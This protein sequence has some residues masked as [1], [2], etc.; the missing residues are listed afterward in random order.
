[1]CNVFARCMQDAEFCRRLANGTLLA[2]S[3]RAHAEKEGVNSNRNRP[4]A[5]KLRGSILLARS[6]RN[7]NLELVAR[8][9]LANGRRTQASGTEFCRRLANGTL[10]A[11]SQRAHAE[12]EGVNS[13]RNCKELAK[14]EPRASCSPAARKRAPYPR[15]SATCELL[16][17]VVCGVACRC[18]APSLSLS[19]FRRENL[20]LFYRHTYA[21]DHGRQSKARQFGR[22]S[23]QLVGFPQ[24]TPCT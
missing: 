21:T 4:F 6:L 17:P 7:P 8:Q 3:Q 22:G 9:P 5:R 2:R 18:K 14:S 23:R 20:T 24:V 13:N 16:S 10:L 12:K 15:T 1:V 11:R 19:P